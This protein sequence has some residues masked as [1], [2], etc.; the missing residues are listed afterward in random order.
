[1]DNIQFLETIKA[2]INPFTGEIISEASFLKAPDVIGSFEDILADLKKSNNF[3]L[4]Y[5]IENIKFLNTLIDGINPATNLPLDENDPLRVDYVVDCLKE[6]EKDYNFLHST[7]NEELNKVPP[8]QET[9]NSEPI[10]TD[11]NTLH[12][13]AHQK[14]RK[15][16]NRKKYKRIK[17]KWQPARNE[18]P[19]RNFIFNWKE[20]GG[21]A[22]LLGI[23]AVISVVI[24]LPLKFVYWD[25]V[26]AVS[27]YRFFELITF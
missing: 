3:D 9:I 8:I 10:E 16:Y 24:F 17:P 21:V 23:I 13:T 6:I 7:N 18:K 1:M 22:L 5:S 4:I 2:G 25:K 26:N 11:S 12:T 14:K 20:F 19:S 15:K 27:I